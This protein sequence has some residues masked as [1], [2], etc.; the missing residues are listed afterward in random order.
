MPVGWPLSRQSSAK[1]QR[2]VTDHRHTA[3]T[4]SYYQLLLSSQMVGKTGDP[5]PLV[6]ANPVSKQHS[7]LVLSIFA[8]WI[9]AVHF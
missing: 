9:L 4:G 8:L 1:V 6:Q 2:Y 3:I 7:A 5:P